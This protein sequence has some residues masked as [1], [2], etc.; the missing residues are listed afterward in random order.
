[1]AS[2]SDIGDARA[3]VTNR[4]H[5]PDSHEG[6]DDHSE[7]EDYN[8]EADEINSFDDHLDNMFAAHEV[9]HQGNVNRK[10]KDTDYWVVDV[11]ENGV[12]SSMEL[13]VREALAL[14]PGKKIV[15]H[16]NRELQQ[17]GQAA[18]LLSGFLG[19]LGS[20]FQQLPI[21]AKSWKTM[22]KASKE[23][24]YDQV[25]VYDEEL[26]F[27]ENI[28]RKPAGIEANH[29]KKFL[30]YR[31]DD[32]TK[33]KCR[34]NAVN[35]SKQQYT[36]TGG[37]KTMARKRH[38]EEQRLGRPIGRGEGWTMSHKKKEWKISVNPDLTC[39]QEAIELVESQDP[40]SKEFSQNDSLAQVLGKEH[41]GRVRGLGIGTCPSQC[42]RN[43]PEQ[44]DY[45]VQIEEY[46]MEIVKLKTEAAELKAEAAELRAAAAAAAEAKRQRMETEAAEGKAK[47]QTMGDLL[48]YVIQQQGG[49]LPP[50]IAAGLDYLR[51]APT[52]SHAR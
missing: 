23:H 6:V 5:P 34:K 18:G 19:T 13:T 20:D 29:W 21:C 28:K 36:H 43:I 41:P 22:T 4:R 35:H 42:F 52:S 49:N 15:L 16:H 40:S 24:A 31:L 39:L 48:T 33:D 32:D 7:D 25:K 47:I 26:T 9:E 30:Q 51:S 8:P 45:G 11:I 38:E 37:S 14:H 46:Q 1:M 12:I 10:K 2:S 3:P 44:S 27:E 17:V 50:E